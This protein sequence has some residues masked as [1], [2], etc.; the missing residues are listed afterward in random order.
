[1]DINTKNSQI[2][3]NINQYKAEEKKDQDNAIKHEPTEQF[4]SCCKP[5][6]FFDFL[7]KKKSDVFCRDIFDPEFMGRDN[8][9]KP[10][11]HTVFFKKNEK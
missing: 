3:N 10:K 11:S 9:N 2:Q 1:M 7:N 8:L 5:V 6:D 4:C